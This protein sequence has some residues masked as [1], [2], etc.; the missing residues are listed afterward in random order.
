M[1]RR[2]SEPGLRQICRC[3]PVQLLASSTILAK[4]PESDPRLPMLQIVNKRYCRVQLT[5]LYKMGP[6][7]KKG[8]TIE[9]E[10]KL[11]GTGLSCWDYVE[12]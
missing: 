6:E 2:V 11:A 7:P 3:A 9:T 8:R 5:E 4:F 10:T 12:P 1:G